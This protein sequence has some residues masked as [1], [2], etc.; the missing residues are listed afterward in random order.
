MP[1]DNLVGSSN[2]C[3]AARGLALRA[4]H[5]RP[6]AIH[7]TID[8]HALKIPAPKGRNL[9][10]RRTPLLHFTLSHDSFPH[11]SLADSA[12]VHV[13]GNVVVIGSPSKGFPN[14]VTKGIVSAKGAMPSEPGT[15]I[16]TDAAINPGNS[17]GPLLNSSGE[18]IGITTQKQFLSNDGRPLQGIGFAL[19][20]G[21]VST[22]YT[23][24]FS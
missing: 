24:P 23:A 18:V 15:W 22:G 1:R 10:L 9:H 2:R 8:P 19:S 13:G 21:D 17:G 5:L 7:R 14:S 12:S 4:A 11:L 6:E 16:Q 20:S 3:L